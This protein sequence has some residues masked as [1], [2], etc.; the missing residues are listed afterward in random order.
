MTGIC[1]GMPVYAAVAAIKRKRGPARLNPAVLSV[2][3]RGHGSAARGSPLAWVRSLVVTV[4][5]ACRV[6]LS[7]DFGCCEPG[8]RGLAPLPLLL[9]L[10]TLR[11]PSWKILLN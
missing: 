2:C 6:R 11:R 3:G 9:H 7:T 8:H 1:R 10:Q 4:N 5:S